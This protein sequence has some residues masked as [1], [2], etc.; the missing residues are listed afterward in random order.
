MLTN[1]LNSNGRSNKCTGHR[2]QLDWIRNELCTVIKCIQTAHGLIQTQANRWNFTLSQFNLKYSV[3]TA[4]SFLLYLKLYF[5]QSV[6]TFKS[7]Q[8]QLLASRIVL[9]ISCSCAERCLSFKCSKQFSLSLLFTFL[10]HYFRFAVILRGKKGVPSEKQ[11]EF[12]DYFVW[13]K[14]RNKSC[15]AL[16]TLKYYCCFLHRAIHIHTGQE[17]TTVFHITPHL[18]DRTEIEKS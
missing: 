16:I 14:A 4:G 6:I 3:E 17:W 1:I 9:R 8:M 2:I 5:I 11:L 7:T 10:I 15:L 12:I 13:F 18:V